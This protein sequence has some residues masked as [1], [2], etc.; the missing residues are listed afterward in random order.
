[1][2]QQHAYKQEKHAERSTY[3]GAYVRFTLSVVKCK[4]HLR[5]TRYVTTAQ[6]TPFTNLLKPLKKPPKT[7][8]TK[9]P[10]LDAWRHKPFH[11]FHPISSF[12]IYIRGAL[13]GCQKSQ[14]NSNKNRNLEKKEENGGK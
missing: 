5:Q 4:E 10:A 8:G 1:M 12:H 9:D 3:A 6:I 14:N 13:V 2:T 7:P 11:G